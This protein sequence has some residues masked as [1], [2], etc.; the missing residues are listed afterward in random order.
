MDK[1]TYSRARRSRAAS[2]TGETTSTLEKTTNKTTWDWKCYSY[3]W[4]NIHSTANQVFK[5]EVKQNV[6]WHRG[7]HSHQRH[8]PLPVDGVQ[9]EDGGCKLKHWFQ[10]TMRSLL[11]RQEHILLSHLGA[12]RSAVSLSSIQTTETLRTESI[13]IRRSATTDD[14]NVILLLTA[15]PNLLC[16]PWFRGVQGFLGIHERPAG[17]KRGMFH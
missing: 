14:D 6:P 10:Y 1:I 12:S 17:G 9:R 11:C 4:D 5:T 16:V 7:H 8:Q 3:K 2:L 15:P 13:S